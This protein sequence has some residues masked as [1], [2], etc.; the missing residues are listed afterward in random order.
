M[1]PIVIIISHNISFSKFAIE[2]I[3]KK[4]A[5]FKYYRS[6]ELGCETMY[7]V[8]KYRPWIVQTHTHS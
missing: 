8:F 5:L 7:S 2:H 3:W 4:R 1:F 6:G